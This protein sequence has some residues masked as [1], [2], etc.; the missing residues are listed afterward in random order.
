MYTSTVELIGLLE[1]SSVARAYSIA[2]INDFWQRIN[3]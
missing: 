2:L 1:Y 3:N